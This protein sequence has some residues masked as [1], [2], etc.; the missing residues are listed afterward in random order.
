MGVAAPSMMQMSLAPHE[1]QLRAK[2]LSIAESAAVTYSATNEGKPELIGNVPDIC[3]RTD[4]GDRAY[5]VECTEG[6]GK[7]VQTVARSFRLYVPPSSCDNDGNN[8]HGNSGG[9]D[10]S[11]PGKSTGTGWS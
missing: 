9:Y 2:N 1:A 4:L 7:Y 3:E 11:N 6:K 10:C 5:K 8:G